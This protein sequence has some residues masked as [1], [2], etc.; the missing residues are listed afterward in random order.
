L[1]IERQQIA[2]SDPVKRPAR[3]KLLQIMG[4]G[5]ITG[6]SDDDPSGI[7]TCSQV[8]APFAHG[9]AWTLIFSYPLI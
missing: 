4:P 5:L 6:T 8:G 1:D 3:P 7:A 9:L 2:A